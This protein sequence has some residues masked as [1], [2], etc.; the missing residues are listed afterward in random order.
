MST[1]SPRISLDSA[2]IRFAGDSGDGMQVSGARFTQESAR[3]GND[4]ATR[5]DFPAEIRAPAGSIPG[6]SAFQIH[7]GSGEIFTAGDDLDALIAMNP[8]ALKANIKDLKQ[9]GILVCNTDSFN[10]KNIK[11]AGYSEDP[12]EQADLNTRYNLI[13][14]P[15]TTLTHEALAEINLPKSA[16]ERCKNFFALGIVCW[17]YGR[18]IEETVGWI[19]LKFSKSPEVAR[20]NRLA[21]EGGMAFAQASE[22]IGDLYEVPKASLKPG[23]YRNITGNQGLA[24]GLV[25]AAVKSELPLIYSGY[26]ITPASDILHEMS[27]HK[28][29]GVM[30][31]QAEDEIA[32]CCAAIGASYGGIL[33]VTASSGPGILLKQEAVALAVMTELP[34]V[35]VNVQRAGPSTGMPTK[36]EQADL[37]QSFFGRNGE[38]PLV[39]MA[40]SSPDDAFMTAFLACKIALEHML[41]VVLL[42]DGY[43]GNGSQPWLLPSESELPLISPGF[44]T[45]LAEGQ[46]FQPYARDPETLARVWARPGTPGMEHRIGGIEKQ[47]IFGNISYDPEN[48]QHMTN[49]RAEKVQR[50]AR[51]LPATEVSGPARGD[52]LVISWG[53][54]HGSVSAAVKAEQQEGRSV[55]HVHLRY[56]NPLPADLDGIMAN[57]KRV[58]VPELNMGQLQWIL[59]AR[60]A[61]DVEG[62]HKVKGQPFKIAEVRERIRQMAVN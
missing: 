8:A 10:D 28:N 39:V 7:F 16:T 30:T 6:V 34:L 35:I 62:L 36:T 26:P 42:S 45:E 40:I 18:G 24:L 29:F 12:L 54:T 21:L 41:P 31:F 46:N 33:G 37:L 53:G 1:T 3:L 13:K 61:R 20:A 9:N 51:T 11:R 52:L 4:L 19:D 48:H 5:P 49:V 14:V 47:D 2:A 43:I 44:I 27:R 23:L 38:C 50:I 57:F 32:A 15:I 59:R 56:L 17:M 55:S 25:A 22:L 60:F 58:L